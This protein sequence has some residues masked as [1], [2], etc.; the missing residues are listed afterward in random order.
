MATYEDFLRWVE[1]CQ[2][3]SSAISAAQSGNSPVC[4]SPSHSPWIL[5]SGA[6]D[7]ITDQ[8]SGRQIG[9]G[10]ESNDLYYLSNPSTTCPTT[11]YHLTIHAQLGHPSLPNRRHHH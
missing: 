3:S 8:L 10:Y 4:I 1:Y 5:D 6:S 2:N 11:N 9:V 7:H